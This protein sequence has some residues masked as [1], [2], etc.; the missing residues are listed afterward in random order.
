ML[1]VFCNDYIKNEVILVCNY[2]E[3]TN[4]FAKQWL[5]GDNIDLTCNRHAF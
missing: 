4:R 3:Y 2:D 1:Q 5:V